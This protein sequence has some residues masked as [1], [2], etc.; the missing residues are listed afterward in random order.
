MEDRKP[1]TLSSIESCLVENA[2]NL[3]AMHSR[4]QELVDRLYGSTPSLAGQADGPRADGAM[5]R[6][7]DVGDLQARQIKDI[8]P[9]ISKLENVLEVVPTTDHLENQTGLVAGGGATLGGE[10]PFRG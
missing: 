2:R 8:F 6:L 5:D 1:A 3:N 9:L 10:V 4:L 7:R